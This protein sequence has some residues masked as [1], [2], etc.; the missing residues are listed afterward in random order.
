MTAVAIDFETANENKASACAIGLAWID[1][2]SITHTEHFLIKPPHQNFSIMNTRLHGLDAEKVK[3][4]QEFPAVWNSI[5]RTND[6]PLILCHNAEFDIRVLAASLAHYSIS[7]SEINFVCTLEISKVVWP[8]LPNHKLDT[9]AKFL[10]QPLIHHNAESDAR[11]CA[12]IALEAIKLT[13]QPHIVG[14]AR[15]LGVEI[16][17][18]KRFD[19]NAGTDDERFL[20]KCFCMS[21]TLISINRDRAAEIIKSLGGSVQSK[22]DNKTD[23]FI[24][25]SKPAE[26]KVARAHSMQIEG[27]KLK[28]LDENNFLSLIS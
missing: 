1:S 9:V 20:G 22:I 13:A 26:S 4:A 6:M 11:M 21:G 7:W 23:Y 2:G 25:G 8:N 28:I 16:R 12:Q 3:E 27:S 15:S 14:A 19:I 10:R 17:K 5:I 24:M 18:L